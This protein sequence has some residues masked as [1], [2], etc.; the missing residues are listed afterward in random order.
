VDWLRNRQSRP[1]RVLHSR[2]FAV[3]GEATDKQILL[4]FHAHFH[5]MSAKIAIYACMAACTGGMQVLL[6]L[7]VGSINQ[8]GLVAMFDWS[9][10][11]VLV[12]TPIGLGIGFKLAGFVVSIVAAH[13]YVQRVTR[14]ELP[15]FQPWLQAAACNTPSPLNCC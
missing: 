10:M 13:S 5:R 3:I 4:T 1:C 7:Q 9:L 2:V 15:V 14:L 8:A 6:L 12:A 11:R